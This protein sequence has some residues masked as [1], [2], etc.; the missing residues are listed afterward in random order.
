MTDMSKAI[1]PSVARWM[2]QNK[3]AKTVEEC[4]NIYSTQEILSQCHDIFYDEDLSEM[5]LFNFLTQSDYEVIDV[6][7]LQRW[8]IK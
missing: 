5:M 6:E 3:P 4:K 7:G 2:E 8:I 1:H